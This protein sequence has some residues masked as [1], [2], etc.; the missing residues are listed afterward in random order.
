MG[1]QAGSEPS[2]VELWSWRDV[3]ASY[4]LTHSRAYLVRGRGHDARRERR[5]A[6]HPSLFG[7]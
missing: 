2:I 3:R 7:P 1:K 4:P 6:T 5:H